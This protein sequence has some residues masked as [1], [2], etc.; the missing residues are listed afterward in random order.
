[1]GA[2]IGGYAAAIAHHV[3]IGGMAPGGYCMSTDLYQE[4]VIIPP[5]RIVARGQIVEDVFSLLRENIR[6]PK[7]MAG[8]FRAQIG[9]T[10]LGHQG[11]G[12]IL[13]RFGAA[14]V[15]VFVDELIDYTER[16]ARSEIARLPEGDYRDECYLDDD[17]TTGRPIKLCLQARV[18]DGTVAF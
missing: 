15:A 6:T 3:D 13:E 11:M 7:Q 18:K 16:W 4:G 2:Q 9:A 17:G 10:P 5:I 14:T 12:A 8:E 1:A